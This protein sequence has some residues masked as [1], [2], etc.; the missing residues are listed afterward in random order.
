MTRLR[1]ENL[2]LLHLKGLLLAIGAGECV[3]L[4]GPS[5]AGKTL[6]LRAIC[7]LVPHSG[8]VWLDGVAS[9]RFRPHAWRRRVGML[10][11]ESRWW[12]DTVGH[13]F[14]DCQEEFPARLGFGA[15]AMTWQVNRLSSG[16]RQR[17]ALL[18]LLC[19]RP[20]VLLLDEPTANLD[21]ANTSRVEAVLDAY[22]KENMAAVLWVSHDRGQIGRI[23]SRCLVL[24]NGLLQE[25]QAPP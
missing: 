6:L 18:R 24:N 1:V 7:D 22:R 19:N 14:K 2:S 23:A 10:P 17:L 11:A 16:E 15:E 9:D 5:G 25:E 12:F 13:H 20:A 3:A 21:A 4:C 8:T